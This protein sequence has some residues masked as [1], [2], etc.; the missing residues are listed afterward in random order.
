MT[1]ILSVR[2]FPPGQASTPGGAYVV[3][4]RTASGTHGSVS[5]EFEDP[6]TYFV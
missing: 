1:A 5:A 4:T 3:L 2:V 6:S